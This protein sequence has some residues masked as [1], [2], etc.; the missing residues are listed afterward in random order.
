MRLWHN[1]SFKDVFE[2]LSSSESGLSNIEAQRRLEHF[3]PNELLSRGES[4]WK[5]IIEPFRS[6]F[7]LILLAAASIS[8]ISG[9]RL[10]GYI[11]SAIII[12]NAAIFYSQR[13]ATERVLK[14]LKRHS[15]QSVAVIRDGQQT[16]VSSRWLVPGDVILLSEGLR[17]P[18]DARLF[19]EDNLYSDESALTGE[20]L[21]VKKTTAL[22]G[23]EIG[24]AHV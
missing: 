6:I 23:Q 19:H 10:D 18:A 14:S 9:E 16:A 8:F 20:S 7:I 1:L 4:L 12:I 21:P 15:E 2:A 24:R 17:I 13:Q 22:E 5:K 11:I 3:G